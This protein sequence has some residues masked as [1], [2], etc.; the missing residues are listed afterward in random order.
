MPDIV[1]LGSLNTD[2]VLDVP[3]LPTAGQT[4]LGGR[5]RV[6]SGGK[7]ANQAV[8]AA[9]QAGP[10]G[11]TVRMVGRVGADE[12]G[13]RMRADLLAAG[14]NAAGVTVDPDE[15]SGTALILVDANGE[16]VIAVAAGANGAV[17]AGDARRAAAGLGPGDIAICQLE[18]P[19]PAV[20]TLVTAV[21][22]AGARSV[23]NAAP[24]ATLAADLLAALDVLV[25][26]ESEARVVLGAEIRTAEAAGAAAGRAGCAVVVTLGAEG[27]VYGNPAGPPGHCPAPAV[28][29]VDTVGAGDAFVGALAVALASGAEL[30]GAVAAG[31][32]AGSRAVTRAGARH[33]P[34]R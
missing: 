1:V 7:G 3:A 22:A 18:V 2:L 27:A 33:D 29:V 15:P 4:V 9:A 14:V 26:N 25:V 17:D 13:R 31:V 12:H 8:A 5:L 23:C 16:N 34:Q 11:P 21:R 24:A 20:R 28:P 32:A 10:A 19:Q 30:P 6:H